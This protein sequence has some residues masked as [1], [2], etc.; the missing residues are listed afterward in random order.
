MFRI[1]LILPAVM[2]VLVFACLPSSAQVRVA[3]ISDIHIG[4][5]Q[6]PDAAAK[7]EKAVAHVNALHPDAVIVSGD[8]GENPGAWQQARNILK[9]LKAPVYYVPGNHDVHTNDVER[10][11]SVFDKDYYTFKVK[12]VTF[13]VIDSQLLGNFDNFDAKTPPKLPPETETESERMVHWM[14]DQVPDLQKAGTVI[15]VQHIPVFR[16]GGFPQDPKPYWVISEPYRGKEMWLLRHMG[17]KNVLVGHWHKG[18]VFNDQGITWHVAPATSWLP[19]GGTL[20]FAMHTINRDGSVATDFYDLDGN[21]VGSYGKAE[22]SST[23]GDAPKVEETTVAA[24]QCAPPFMRNVTIC[25]PTSGAEVRSPV[26]IS[27]AAKGN[28]P[29]TVIQLYVDGNKVYENPGQDRL[30]TSVRLPP[31]RHEVVVQG[32][33]QTGYFKATEYVTVQ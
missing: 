7:L 17:I 11:R 19:W 5:K 25:W 3:Q 22:T 14:E 1:S 27:A 26:Q 10:Y 12:N 2:A 28:G 31:G 16:N 13:L 18:M 21:K 4:V 23:A 24:G 20:G 8:I 15:A 29:L 6:A 9:K 30:T 32:M 33:D